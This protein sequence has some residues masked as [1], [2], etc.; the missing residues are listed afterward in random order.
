MELHIC[1][2][3]N[4]LST[5]INQNLSFSDKKTTGYTL[6]GAEPTTD[7]TH[8]HMCLFIFFASLSSLAKRENS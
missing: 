5:K 3:I 2:Y 6:R 1:K 4:N 8:T 7:E